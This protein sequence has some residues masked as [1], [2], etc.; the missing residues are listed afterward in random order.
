MMLKAVYLTH[1]LAFQKLSHLS[2]LCY[3][4]IEQVRAR[5]SRRL[6]V[7]LEVATGVD[8]KPPYVRAALAKDS[9]PSD[10]RGSPGPAEGRTI[11]LDSPVSRFWLHGIS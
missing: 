6:F 7:A 5:L 9:Q 4:T 8:R 1:C 11:T 3:Y 10:L 2:G